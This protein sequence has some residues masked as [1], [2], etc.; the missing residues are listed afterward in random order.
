M[1]LHNMDL[2]IGILA[3]QYGLIPVSH[4]I[5]QDVTNIWK[6][7]SQLLGVIILHTLV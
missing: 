6:W 2:L 7:H 4:N 5:T 1:F 3:T